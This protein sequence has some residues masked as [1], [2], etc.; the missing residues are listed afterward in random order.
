MR[1]QLDLSSHHSLGALMLRVG[2]TRQVVLVP[3][4]VWLRG[5]SSKVHVF[6]AAGAGRRCSEMMCKVHIPGQEDL[7]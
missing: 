1:P 3:L 6:F 7:Q 4:L 5:S 2:N